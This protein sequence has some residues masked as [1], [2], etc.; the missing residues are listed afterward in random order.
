MPAALLAAAPIDNLNLPSTPYF[1]G[2]AVHFRD[3]QV[4]QRIEHRVIDIMG[5]SERRQT[6]R[7]TALDRAADRVQFNDGES[8]SD[9]MGNTLSNARG[10]M[11]TP[12]QFYPAELILGRRW[13][14]EFRQSRPSGMVY[15]FRYRVRVA[16]RETVVVPAG[17]FEAWRIEAEGFNVGLSAHIRRT[18]WVV[19]G[20]PGDVAADTFVRLR[21]GVVEQNERQ[22]LI[23]IHPA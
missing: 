13:V 20:L 12:R 7:V 18:L 10:A 16:A 14:T 3:Y 15:T 19:P 11:S 1:S 17:R 9:L 5:R 21:N 2:Q 4:G 23:A 6:L 22:E 8:V